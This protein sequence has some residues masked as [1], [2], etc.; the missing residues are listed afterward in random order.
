MAYSVQGSDVINYPPFSMQCW[1]QGSPTPGVSSVVAD[2]T[3][4]G[5]DATE[6]PASRIIIASPKYGATQ[7]H[8]SAAGSLTIRV[9]GGTSITY[10]TWYFDSKLGIWVGLSST[11]PPTITV[12]TLPFTNLAYGNMQGAK[13]YLS[14][15]NVT[16]AVLGVGYDYV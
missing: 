15:H 2:T 8:G 11:T 4:P 7:T 1:V 14:I 6:P 10:R 9:V 13:M 16:G 12:A 3:G 5:F